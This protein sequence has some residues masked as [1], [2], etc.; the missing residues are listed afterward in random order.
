MFCHLDRIETALFANWSNEMGLENKASLRKV[1]QSF[2]GTKK[3]AA[4]YLAHEEEYV[5]SK[6]NSEFLQLASL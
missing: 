1:R 6:M 4:L 2:L 5:S 3:R